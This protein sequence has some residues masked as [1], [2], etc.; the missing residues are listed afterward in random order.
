MK[1]TKP[2][3]AYAVGLACLLLS[4]AIA[5][6]QP[7]TIDFESFTGMTFFSGNPVPAPSQLSSQLLLTS[8][9][10]FSSESTPYVAVVALGGGHATSGINGIG[11]VDASG[12]LSYATPIRIEFFLPGSPTTPA[13]TDFVSIRNDLIANGTEPVTIEAFDVSGTLLGRTTMIDDHTF[14][15][16]LSAPGIH[17][18]RISEGLSPGAAAFDD[19]TFNGAL[20]A[21]PEPSTWALFAIGIGALVILRLSRP[22]NTALEPTRKSRSRGCS[23]GSRRWRVMGFHAAPPCG[24]AWIR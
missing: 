17:S 21:V 18:V 12:L 6:A 2:R 1:T 5:G 16:S 19:F 20:V 7:V 4:V 10:T 14:T 15:L 23:D 24:S 11:G 8:G 22:P 3:R 9:L 13:A